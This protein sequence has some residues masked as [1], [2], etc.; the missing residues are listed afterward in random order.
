MRSLTL[1]PLT[2][3]LALGVSACA[4][5][6]TKTS[7][8]A[9][10]VSTDQQDQA[11]AALDKGEYNDAVTRYS[12]M[13]K[14]APGNRN[15]LIGLGEAYLG[16]GQAQPAQD[17]FKQ[18]L[19]RSPA[20]LDAM[21]GSGLAYMG[22]EQPEQAWTLLA[23]V[24]QRD[25]QAWRSMNTL[26]LI[27]DLNNQYSAAMAWYERALNAQDKEAVIYN[28]YG[29]SRIMA[30]D[31][32]QAETLLNYGLKLDPSNIRLR[33]NLIQAIAWQGQYDRAL[34][35][36]GDIPLHVALNNV[37]YIAMLRKDMS[38]AAG[39]FQKALDA[40]PT[41]YAMAAANLDSAR[42]TLS[43]KN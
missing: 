26:G 42:H 41:W 1:L 11:K 28:N 27:C 29:Y 6:P 18:V 30:H 10:T 8:Q 36:R 3:S 24:V 9:V 7:P 34:T 33:N 32:A 17:A 14:L 20:D 38:G 19:L 35:M 15:Y 40:S 31:F 4:S 25:P 16:L 39:L 22:Q 37:G 23:Q 12:E 5:H 13:L 21:E 2:I 43:A